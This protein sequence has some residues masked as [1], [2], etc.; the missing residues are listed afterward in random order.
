MPIW[1]HQAIGLEVEGLSHRPQLTPSTDLGPGVTRFAH[2]DPSSVY[3]TD[4]ATGRTAVQAGLFV[5]NRQA[6]TEADAPHRTGAVALGV[7][8]ASD[9]PRTV[10]LPELEPA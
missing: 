4:P 8:F 5:Y 9:A 10:P 1:H 6:L 3:S 7:P 2:V